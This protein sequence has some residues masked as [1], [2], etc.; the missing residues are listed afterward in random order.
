MHARIYQISEKPVPD[1]NFISE[2]AYDEG[3]WFTQ[4]VAEYV[5][6]DW[7]R[8]ASIN[9]LFEDLRSAK[10]FVGVLSTTDGYHTDHSF[11]LKPGFHRAYFG[12]RFERFRLILSGLVDT[13]SF[14][15]FYDMRISADLLDLSDIYN[16]LYCPYVVL[17]TGEQVKL[18]EF[19]RR[20]RTNKRYYIGGTLDYSF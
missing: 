9:C 2:R 13:V 19:L 15:D 3:H 6:E 11:I 17:D 10:E 5:A 1:E 20:A 18:T 8:D 16:P 14:D 12:Q 4:D 7:N